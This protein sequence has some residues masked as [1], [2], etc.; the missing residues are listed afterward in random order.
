MTTVQRPSIQDM[1]DIKTVAIVGVSAKMGYYWVHSMLQW[2]HDLRVWLVSKTEGEVLG[3]KIYSN[4]D[5]IPEQIDYVIIAVPNKYVPTIL[6][7][8][9]EKGAKGAT[10]F[11]SGYAELGTQEGREREKE[12]TDLIQSLPVRVL[13]PNCMGLTYP[14]IGF[15]FMPTAKRS[16]GSV[17]FLSQSGGIAIAVYTAGAESGIG[18]SKLFSFG[19]QIDITQP[20]LMRYFA[21]DPETTVV[22]AYIEGT[23]DGRDLLD[24]MIHLASKKPLVVLKGGRSDEGSRAASSHTGAL[25]GSNDIWQAAFKQANVP[26]VATLEDMVA[27]LSVFSQCPRPKSNSVGIVAISGG[28]SVVYTDLCVE[29]GLNVP[30]TSKETIEKLDPLI[31]DVGTGLGNPIDLAAD[32]YQD[33]TI[34]EVIRIVGADPQFDSIII[35][36][37]VHN[38]YQIASIM[39][40]LDVTD[41][42]WQ[43]MAEA[44]SDVMQKHEKPVLVAIPDVAFPEA[45]AKTWKIFVDAGL[46]TFR[47]MPE[48]IE[49]LSRVWSYYEKTGRRKQSR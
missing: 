16:A 33:Q 7:Q 39:D 46:P 13:G 15:A 36:A 9:V 44:G 27:T 25:A 30:R 18:F 3:H 20:E 12:L 10:V 26:T 31:A 11:T 8:A 5:H 19:N 21:E 45:R 38:I 6:R 4:L 35:E 2:P 1:L 43:A 40:A 48:A 29:N 28:T 24:A 32:Y 34:S 22:G 14:K 42:F 23:K 47:N 49:A 17:G 41:Y 37:D